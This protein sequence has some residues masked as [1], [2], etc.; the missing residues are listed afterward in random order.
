M[1]P[2]GQM[3]HWGNFYEIYAA[4]LIPLVLKR[5][6]SSKVSKK[7]PKDI[8]KL[9]EIFV[10]VLDGDGYFDIGAQKQSLSTN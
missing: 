8:S 10:G 2:Y 4:S 1:L 5:K 9:I 7:Y 6:V 3:S